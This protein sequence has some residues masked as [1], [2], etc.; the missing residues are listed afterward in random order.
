VQFGDGVNG[1]I[2]RWL[3]G[4]ASN[5]DDADVVNIKATSFRWGGGAAANGGAGTI[6]ALR[7]AIPYVASVTNLMPAYGGADEESVA[8]AQ[9]RAPQVLRTANRAVTPDDFAF[10]AQETPGAEIARAKAFAL[11]NP[12]FRMS[13]SPDGVAAVE[14]PAPGTITVVVVPQSDQPMPTPNAGTLQLVANWLDQHRL[15]TAEL[16]VAPPRY[17]RVEIDVSLIVAPTAD[18]GV[19]QAAALATLTNYFHP[20]KGGSSG[21]GWDFGG[22]LY[23]SETYRQLLEVPG[24]QRIVTG[25]L[26]TYVD[27]E[28]QPSA[29]DVALAPDELVYSLNHVIRAAYP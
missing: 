22:T 25:T 28:L 16:Y 27:D 15:L 5:R 6:S 9:V 12:N 19:V 10:L 20:L 1:A 18:L 11:L 24:V 4:N 7:S 14:T 8:D 3:S 2:P 29:S 21:Q 26:K 23:F 13:W 17:R